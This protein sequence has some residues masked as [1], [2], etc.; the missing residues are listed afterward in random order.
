MPI[1]E[2]T[3]TL[4]VCGMSCPNCELRIEN[5]LKT[6]SGIL[7]V[8]VRYAN[9]SIN[10]TYNPEMISISAIIEAIESLDYTVKTISELHTAQHNNKTALKGKQIIISLGAVGVILIAI[11][12]IG[13]TVGFDLVSNIDPSMG[14]GILFV[15]GLI[16]SLHCITM[17][18]GINLSLCVSYKSKSE[19]KV[20]PILPSVLYNTGRVISYTIIGG[21]VGAIGSIINISAGTRGIGA[22]IAGAFMVLMGLN[23]LNIFPELR[24]VVPQMPKIV[25]STLY[26]QVGA[27]GPFVVGL[28]NGFMPC[29]PL[30]TMQLY[31][32]GTGSFISG[33][34]SM[35]IFSLG[36]V[37]LMFG[38]GAVSSILSK[39]FTASMMKVSA[40]LVISV[41]AVMLIMGL[42]RSL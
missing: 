37:P 21:I 15:I 24:K 7:S 5:K 28:L 42:S 6:L 14:Y 8:D 34:L 41:G 11:F 20:V 35:L 9:E 10:L 31:A 36:T 27:K 17:C 13:T 38:F 1:T 25:G 26:K 2:L 23:M 29:G 40:L 3:N 4:T 39:K 16:N 32:L 18:G 12:I 33:A 19:D 22:I 30:Q